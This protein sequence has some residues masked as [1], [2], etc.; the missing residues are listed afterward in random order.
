M[1]PTN[2]PAGNK[3]RKPLNE[4]IRKLL[5][6]NYQKLQKEELKEL[7]DELALYHQELEEREKEL[8]CLYNLLKITTSPALS[9][10]EILQ[11]AVELIPPAWNY[12]EITCARIIFDG[13]TYKTNNFMESSWKQSAAITINNE[14]KGEVE[15]FY[16]ENKP[17]RHEG[18]FL[19]EERNLINAIANNLS[20]YLEQKQAEIKNRENEERFRTIVEG[21][22]DPIF[23]QSD[24]KFAYLNPAACRLFRVESADKLLGTPVFDRFH[25]D[26]HDKI[27]ERIQNINEGKTVSKLFEQRFIRMD[28]TEVWVETVGE[29]IIYKNKNSALVFVRDISDRKLAE[30]ELR[31]LYDDSLRIFRFTPAALAL[32][33]I[34]DGKFI[35]VNNAYS[36]IMEYQPDEI[37]GR[38]VEDLNIYIN[39]DER[40]HLVKELQEHGKVSDYEL[41]V[42]SK[43]GAFRNLFL[44]M[45]AT[46]YN[47]EKIILSTFIDITER[48]EIENELRNLKSD[49]ENQVHEKTKELQERVVE[50]ER[51]QNATVEREF[52][53]KELREEIKKLK[54]T[55]N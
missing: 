16:L 11:H 7:M 35:A 31:Q 38:T 10:A 53:I 30:Q 9:Q 52:R 33:R 45:E 47:H 21:A 14:K 29:P 43:T 1:E 23:I 28:G 22:P 44:S 13:N 32:T 39:A 5:A 40:D 36:K 49:L 46:V 41:L 27:G 34:S 18:P 26:Y 12:P 6:G 51:F 4:K 15:V 3:S 50:L 2:S 55:K 42:R 48:K 37:I 17:E 8:D 54:G 19:R 24:L 25:P 20:S